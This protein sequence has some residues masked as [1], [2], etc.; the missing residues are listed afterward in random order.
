MIPQRCDFS[1]FGYI[2]PAINDAVNGYKMLF[3]FNRLHRG[4]SGC[5]VLVG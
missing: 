3:P 4:V 1:G 5:V 2:L